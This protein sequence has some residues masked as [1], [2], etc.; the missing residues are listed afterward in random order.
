MKKVFLDTNII[1]D[2]LEHREPFF[3]QSA[4]ILELGYRKKLNLYATSLSFINGI[5]V[6]RKTIG[7][8]EAIDKVKVLRQIIEISPMS[9]KEFDLALSSPFKDIEDSLQYF[10]ALSAR[11]NVIITRNKNDFPTSKKLVVLTPQEFF[12]FYS[13]ELKW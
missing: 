10:S 13:D 8:D 5:Y 4:N 11:C 7:K 3:I 9:A 2:I 1:I 12:D 6:C